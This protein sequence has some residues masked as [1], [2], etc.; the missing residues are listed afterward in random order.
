MHRISLK[1]GPAAFRIASAWRQPLEQLKGL[2]Q[3]YPV[4]TGDSVDFT[5]L[6]EPEKPWRRYIRPS[7]HIGGDFWLPDA[8]P[9]PLSQG[10]LAAEMG[11]N[12]QMALGWRRH[13][14]L[15]ASSVEKDGKAL[16]MT[17]LSGSGKSTLSA[18]LAERGWRFMGDEFALLGLDSG[19]I[20]AFPRLISLKNQSIEAMQKVAPANR[21][22]P[23]MKATPK[24][25]I[26]HLVP[27]ANAIAKMDEPAKPALLL[28]P[29]F[30]HAP[31]LRDMGKSEIFVRL[32]QAS[33]NYVALGEAGFRALTRFVDQV[34]T[35]AMDYQSAEQAEELIDGL[36]SRLP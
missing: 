34:P 11:M 1:I 33:T 14:L 2:Y 23:E 25:D 35:K 6:L 21:F 24:G 15:H 16:V 13:L 17:G 10:L 20:T 7:V 5:V 30:G 8:A 9:L 12:L 31:E 27:P 3:D 32:T 18:M 26:R 29:R 36:W 28:F 22:G 19:E 4:P